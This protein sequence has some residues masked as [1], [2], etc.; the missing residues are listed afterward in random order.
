ML[1]D[2][3]RGKS[4]AVDVEIRGERLAGLRQHVRNVAGLGGLDSNDLVVYVP[5]TEFLDTVVTEK[6]SEFAGVQMVGVIRQAAEFGSRDLLGR[7]ALSAN[8]GLKA[9]AV[10]ETLSSGILEPVGCQVALFVAHRQRKG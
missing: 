3:E 6:G 8:T 4:A 2:Q 9:H 5:D 1:A 10:C 7:E